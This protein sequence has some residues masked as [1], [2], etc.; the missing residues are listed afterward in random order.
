VLFLNPG[1]VTR[2]NRGAQRSVA[3]LQITRGQVKWR[4]IPFA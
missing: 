2:P 3:E 1:C 4:L